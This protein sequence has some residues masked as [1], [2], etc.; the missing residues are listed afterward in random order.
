MTAFVGDKIGAYVMYCT[1][2]ASTLRALP[3]LAV[4]HILNRLTVRSG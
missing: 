1:N 4:V 3:Q 2:A